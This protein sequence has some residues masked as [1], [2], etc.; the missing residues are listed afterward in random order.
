MSFRKAAIS[1]LKFDTRLRGGAEVRND[2]AFCLAVKKRGWKLIYNPKIA[3]DHYPA[4][5]YEADKRG[6]Y[7][8]KAVEDGAHNETLVLLDYL[9]FWRKVA[10][11]FYI[12]FIGNIFTPGLAAFV[13]TAPREKGN[14]VLRLLAAYKGRWEALKTYRNSK[15]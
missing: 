10:Y 1:G 3:V 4:V 6:N 15:K 13:K 8:W 9:S 12:I 14:S 5:R 2:T 7:D 11:L